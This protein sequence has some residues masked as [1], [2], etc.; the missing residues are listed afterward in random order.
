MLPESAQ[1]I[2]SSVGSCFSFNSARLVSIIPGVQKPHW[3]PCSCLKAAWIGCSRPPAASAS[4][5]VTCWPSAWTASMVQDFTGVPSTSTVQAPQWVVSHPM[6]VPVSLSLSRKK[7]T[8]RSR[9]STSALLF[10]PLTVTVIGWPP[11]S[12]SPGALVG[13]LQSALRKAPDDVAFVLDGTAM[14]GS[15]LGG[16]RRQGGRLLDG[17]VIQPSA[18]QRRF[19]FPGFD[20]LRADGGE[21]DAGRADLAVI[22][23]EMNRHRHG[24]EVTHLA[25][26]LEVGATRLRPGDRDPD[27]T[28][29]LG[30]L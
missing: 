16:F 5:V 6:W 17:G 27:L 12:H 15:R 25:L 8:R 30:R 28:Q 2:S 21:P 26:E 22:H 24:G 23:L 3:S 10:S 29:D 14:V 18:P 1:R 7:C 9:G 19:R 13:A 4:T 11:S 20:V